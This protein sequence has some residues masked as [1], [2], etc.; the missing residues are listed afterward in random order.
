[1]HMKTRQIH[2]QHLLLMVVLAS[3]ITYA[4][5]N[6]FIKGSFVGIL[7]AAAAYIALYYCNSLLSRL[8]QLN[9]QDGEILD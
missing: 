4:L 7:F 5:I 8:K 6:A 1:M 9:E 2:L 3:C